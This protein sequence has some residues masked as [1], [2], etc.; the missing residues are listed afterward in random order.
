MLAILAL[1][2]Y[3]SAQVADPVAWKFT[4]KKINSTSWEIQVTAAIS[5]GWHL[6]SQDPGEGPTPT[7]IKFSKNPAVTFSGRVTEAGK[8]QKKFEKNFGTV[9][10]FYEGAVTFVQRV[11]IKAGST[12]KVTASIEYMLCDEK[13]CLPPKSKGFSVD[14]GK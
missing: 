13:E 9:L 12:A 6:F 7:R 5:G 1:P 14:I 3:G 8:L 2:L 4:S 11:T 10:K